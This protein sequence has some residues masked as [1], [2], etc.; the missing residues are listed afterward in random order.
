LTGIEINGELVPRAIDEF[1]VI[2]VAATFAAGVTVITDDAAELRVKE[3]DRIE[4]ICNCLNQ[5]GGQ[6]EPLADGM[7]ITGTGRLGWRAR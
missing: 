2:S 4:A 3:T 5:L 7:R 6:A 1:P